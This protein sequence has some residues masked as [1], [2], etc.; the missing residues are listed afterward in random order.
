MDKM[1]GGE[2]EKRLAAMKGMA[3]KGEMVPLS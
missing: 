3:E 1:I 2:F